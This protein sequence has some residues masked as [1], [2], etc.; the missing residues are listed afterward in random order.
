MA[1]PANARQNHPTSFIQAFTKREHQKRI[2]KQRPKLTAEQ[3]A[4][5]CQK[6]KESSLLNPDYADNTKINIAGILRKWKKYCETVKLK[7]CCRKA[8]EEADRAMSMDF[9]LHLCETYKIQSWGTSWEYFRQYKQLYAS[10][11]GKLMDRND[12]NE[13]KKW[14]DATLVPRYGLSPPKDGKDVGDSGDLLALQTFNI[15]YDTG[16][17]PRERHRL[18]LS[19][20]YLIL[21]C[22]GA[23]PA[24]VV[25]NEKVKQIRTIFFFTT[26]RKLIFCL[27]TIV[28]SLAVCDGAFQAQSLTSA[29]QVFQT[30]NLGPVKC[31]PFRW[32]KEWLKRPVFRRFN[33]AIISDEPLQ[34]HRLKDD[35][36]RQSLDSG[37]N[38]SDAVRDQMMRH[39]PKWA[40]FN[41]AYINEKVEFHLQNAF[42]EEPTEDGLIGML[43]HIGLMRDPRASKNMVP[44]EV[45]ENMPA[46]PDIVELEAERA[47]LKSGKHRI[48]GTDNEQRIRDLTKEIR[49]KRANRRKDIQR[50]YRMDYFYNRPTWEIEEQAKGEEEVYIKPTVKLCIP[51][52]AQLAKILCEQP[53]DLSSKKLLE[54]RIEAADLMVALCDKR[55][56]VKRGPTRRT[57]AVANKA[58]PGDPFPLLMDRRQCPRCIGDEGLSYEERTFK[59]CRPSVMY[60]HFDREHAQQLRTQISCNHPKCKGEAP[61]QHL[62]HFKGHVQETHGIKL[63][64]SSM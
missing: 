20:C 57:L 36:A 13:V 5:L 28:V 51:E 61:F 59:Y 30:K 18:Q 2:A 55:E 7:A 32:K 52:R 27:I 8:I 17:F 31:T 14:H 9:L 10:V 41:S 60:D 15:A 23:R 54:L 44:D 62:N 1:P 12:S 6:L 33:G 37:S 46:D 40:T 63:R 34:Y 38:A 19:A 4:A 53:K 16:I 50:E 45:W 39:D 58:P 64:S 48:R 49:T 35:M 25:D 21:A 47:E 22:T 43:S 11:T 56:T 3:H 24:E 42:L 26:T 29:R